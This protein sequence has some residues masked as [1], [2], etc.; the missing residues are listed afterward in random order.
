M[1]PWWSRFPNA[2][3]LWLLLLLITAGGA[4]LRFWRID[5]QGYWYDEARTIE[6]IYGSLDHLLETL[7][8]QGFPPGWYILIRT[9]AGV[10]ERW[11]GS[12]ATAFS[13]AALRRCPRC[14]AR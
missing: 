1:S 10:I 3:F 7:S 9:W 4:F 13:P 5:H 8:K 14:S 12:G 11:T 6:R 2:R